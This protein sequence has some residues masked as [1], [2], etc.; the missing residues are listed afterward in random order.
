MKNFEIGKIFGIKIRLHSSF[1]LFV[2]IAGAYMSGG[3]PMAALRSWAIL[4]T[5]FGF[6]LLHELGHSLVARRFG[7]P[8]LSIT[9]FPF[10]GA[11]ATG[12]MPRRALREILIALAGPAVNGVLA[13][14]LFAILALGK[15]P[16]YIDEAGTPSFL[17]YLL[18]ANVMLA[19]FNLVPAFPMDGGRILRA[20]L[21]LRLSYL[22]ATRIAVFVGR[23]FALGFFLL[24]LFEPGLWQLAFIG[25][26]LFL[27]GR[28]ELQFVEAQEFLQQHRVGEF[29]DKRPWFLGDRNTRIAELC[30]AMSQNED[31]AFGVLDLEGLHYGIFSRRELLAACLAMPSSLEV[32]RL[33]ERPVRGLPAQLSLA[34]AL[35]L[36]RRAEQGRLPVVE[37]AQIVGILSLDKLPARIDGF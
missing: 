27:S 11:A 25:I 13:I 15:L 36:L 21:F 37:G 4:S 10:G 14:P 2:F 17:G 33:V 1:L 20:L 9:L 34:R 19:L 3:D 16:L 12:P 18:L 30:A 6:V 29:V 28:R 5:L 35:P 8:V 24:V 32:R 31:L 7:I 26:F 23:A 22:R